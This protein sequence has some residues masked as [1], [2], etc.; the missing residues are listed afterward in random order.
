MVHGTDSEPGE[1]TGVLPAVDP[2]ARGAITRSAAGRVLNSTGVVPRSRESARA[3]SGLAPWIR[4]NRDRRT[5]TA[6][7]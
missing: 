1:L 4:T 5:S 3:G 2:S 7:A 6:G